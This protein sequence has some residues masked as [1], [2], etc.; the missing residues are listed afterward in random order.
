MVK[1]SVV[2]PCYN[3]EDYLDRYFNGLLNQTFKDFEIIFVDDGST[4]KTKEIC[5][6]YKKKLEKESIKLTYLYQ[7]NQGQAAALNNGLQYVKGEFL[8]WPDS[9]DYYE[10]EAFHKMVTFLENNPEYA[11]VRGN[12][13]YRREQDLSI[14]HIGKPEDPNKEDVFI[15][16]LLFTKNVACYVGILMTRTEE[17]KKANNGLNIYVSR[18]GQNWQMI[19]PITY[20]RKSKYIDEN[21]YNYVVRDTSHSHV[22]RNISQQLE[23]EKN[24]K[25][26]LLNTLKRIEPSKK[27]RKPY[28]KMIKKKYNPIIL[29]L[30]IKKILM[31]E[32]WYGKSTR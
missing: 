8:I 22:K 23:R 5:D 16:Y 18:T 20:K 32:K 24:K 21:I 9:D 6:T 3:G 31:M 4:D 2:T 14:T 1:L 25:A 19:L 30:Y 7:K 13:I 10:P 27:I 26:I 17:F 28:E 11:S 29:K 15:D 12:V